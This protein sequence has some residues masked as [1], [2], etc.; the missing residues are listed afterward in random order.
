MNILAFSGSLR[1]ASY[2]QLL[3]GAAARVATEFGATVQLISLRDYPLPIFSEDLEK[4]EPPKNAQLLKEFFINS[5]GFLIAS[6]EY[7]S[8][9]TAALKNVIDWVSRTEAGKPPLAGFKGKTGALLSA[10]TGAL[11]GLRGL[12]HLRAILGN[13]GVHVLPDQ[14]ALGKAQEAF[15][16]DGSLKDEKAITAVRNLTKFF[17]DV[18][19]ALH[20]LA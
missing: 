1:S 14:Y 13:I 18:T 4:A 16:P 15:N 20:R 3:V 10:S 9:V 19:R 17:C 8:S 6:P 12:I 11:G 7:N 5:H 2:N